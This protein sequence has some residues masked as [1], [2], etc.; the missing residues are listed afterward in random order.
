MLATI[1]TLIR[2]FH[3]RIH[4]AAGFVIAYFDDPAQTQGCALAIATQTHREVE[5]CGCQLSVLVYGLRG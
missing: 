1:E 2:K 4:E 3:G 5:W